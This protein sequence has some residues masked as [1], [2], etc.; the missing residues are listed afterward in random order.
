MKRSKNSK[1]GH[2]PSRVMKKLCFNNK[3]LESEDRWKN[4][5]SKAWNKQ[6]RNKKRNKS[7]RNKQPLQRSNTKMDRWVGTCFKS[8]LY[9][10]WNWNNSILLNF[11]RRPMT[12]DTSFSNME[13]SQELV[14]GCKLDSVN[15]CQS[16][17]VPKWELR[18]SRRNKSK[19]K[20]GPKPRE[21]QQSK[22]HLF[23]RIKF[24]WFALFFSYFSLWILDRYHLLSLI[25][26]QSN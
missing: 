18:R 26:Y 6:N 12:I 11:F 20:E 21:R 22:W 24:E 7:N 3:N 4:R 17:K 5:E 25:A 1:I 10:I 19:K 8:W 16:S 2:F 9:S 14:L 13:Q 23:R 15:L